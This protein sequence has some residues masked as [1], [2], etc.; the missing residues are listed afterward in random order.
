[1][2]GLGGHPAVEPSPPRDEP[3]VARAPGPDVPDPE[4]YLSRRSSVA[5]LLSV[6]LIQ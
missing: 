1:M 2:M 6:M 4:S 5:L 3:R